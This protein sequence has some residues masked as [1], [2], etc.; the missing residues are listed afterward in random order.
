MGTGSGQGG[1]RGGDEPGNYAS[2]QEQMQ[3]MQARQQALREE[4]QQ[5]K[6][7]L[8]QLAEMIAGLD[9]AGAYS[10]NEKAAEAHL[11]AAMKQMQAAQAGLAGS[12]YE[13]EVNEKKLDE[14]ADALGEAAAELGRTHDLLKKSLEESEDKKL[15]EKAEE[16][17]KEL[18]ELADAY[19]EG[20]TPEEAA[21]MQA[22]LKAANEMLKL[23][24]KTGLV[25][26]MMNDGQTANAA[27]LPW[28]DP[29]GSGPGV[30]LGPSSSGADLSQRARLVARDFWSASVKVK[31]RAGELPEREG[32]DAEFY[33]LENRFY[34]VA[35]R[36]ESARAKR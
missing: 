17:A 3:M 12:Y 35:A 14:A 28:G 2:R 24:M 18:A 32:S 19:E 10:K 4:A 20:V 16:M 31:Q 9:E 5:L 6:R 23:L 8:A 25:P 26:E 11:G 30:G 29:M 34:E 33:E 7:D 21:R 36:T 1:G 22:A 27:G 15:A 13:E